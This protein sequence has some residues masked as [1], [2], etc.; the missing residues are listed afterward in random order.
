M[1][2]GIPLVTLLIVLRTLVAELF[3]PGP[4]R[5]HLGRG[6]NLG[7]LPKRP[8]LRFPFRTPNPPVD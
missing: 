3:H 6:L 7:H 1:I 8:K 5:S 2:L 4:D